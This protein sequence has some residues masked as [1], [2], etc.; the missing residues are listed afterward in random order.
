[1]AKSPAACAA[2]DF[3]FFKTFMAFRHLSVCNALARERPRQSALAVTFSL[4]CYIS[5]GLALAALGC[6]WQH[7]TFGKELSAKLTEDC[8]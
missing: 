6:H 5:R 7:A 1:M 4:D 8:F 2:G 3:T